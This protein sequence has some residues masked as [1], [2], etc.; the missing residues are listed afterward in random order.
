MMAGMKKPHL[1]QILCVILGLSVAMTAATAMAQTA[2]TS[3]P[4]SPGVFVDVPADYEF[5]EALQFFKDLKIIRGYPDQTFKSEAPVTRAEFLKMA[6]KLSGRTIDT[7]KLK[8][9]YK[10]VA[11]S[12]WFFDDVMTAHTLG[13]AQGY[14]GAQF[15]PN[16]YLTR[17]EALKLAFNAMQLSPRKDDMNSKDPL[18]ADLKSSAWYFPYAMTARKLFVM[19]DSDDGNFYPNAVMNRGAAAEILFRVHQVKLASGAPFDMSRE[20]NTVSNSSSGISFKSPKSWSVSDSGSVVTVRKKHG[21]SFYDDELI[22]PLHAKITF[23]RDFAVNFGGPVSSVSEFF[24]NIRNASKSSYPGRTVEFTE[25]TLQGAPAIHVKILS[26]GIEN[27]FVY[28]PEGRVLVI[29][30][31][32]GIGSLTPRLRETLRTMVRSVK[33]TAV[34]GDAGSVN[35]DA[36]LKSTIQQ[37]VLVEKTGKATINSIGDA[38]VIETDEIGV[39][40]GAVDYYYSAKLEITL[41]YERASDTILAIRNGKTTS[42]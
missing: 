26:D 37:Q 24:T 25:V 1:F 35:V 13:I 12:D 32:Y 14:T 39:G 3:S 36:V 40:T 8:S 20:W 27:W 10:D 17:T 31:R 7:K 15:L 33:L 9:I 21:S 2:S 42:F 38:L 28:L 19:T 34:A 4:G 22:T 6:I 5:R 41:K 23:R 11:V 30:G 16:N 29:Y 18:P